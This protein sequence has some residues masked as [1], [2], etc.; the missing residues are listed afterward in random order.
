MYD[1]T[2]SAIS[3]GQSVFGFLFL[4]TVLVFFHEL[5]HFFVA[6]K[7]GVRVESFS[8]GFGKALIRWKDYF[9]TE[10]RIGWIPMGGYV[11]MYGDGDATSAPD[12]AIL[13]KMSD[14]EKK[15]AFHF[16]SLWRRAL[17]IFAGPMANYII[18]IIVFASFSFVYG[19]DIASNEVNGVVDKMPAA[20]AG[21]ISGDK[22]IAVNGQ[23]VDTSQE[24]KIAVSLNNQNDN[25]PLILTI[26]RNGVQRI[27]NIQPKIQESEHRI[28]GKIKI[29]TLGIIF[30]NRHIELNLLDSI[31]NATKQSYSM[32]ITILK[33][34]GQILS[35]QRGFDEFSGPLK[36]AQY[37][38]K[39]LRI[40]IL[41]LFQLLGVI[42][43]NLG[44]INLLPIPPLDG[45]HLF[46]YMI[47]ALLGRSLPNKIQKIAFR[48][49]FA[50]F[51][52][53]MIVSTWN[54]IK[55]FIW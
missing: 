28:Y 44:L 27:L 30:K 52:L 46:M 9:G 7:M 32:S 17:I 5:G 48:L 42:S 2:Q 51:I 13:G 4:I 35:G 25:H 24:V 15:Y 54:D 23:K 40:S 6:R 11:K 21:M 1:L 55:S 19:I 12:V 53:L 45:G 34:I 50:M 37:S 20:Y 38:G 41:E 47:E 36:I 43:L 33:G 49:G 26:E 39:S 3:L 16:Q 31:W 14:D 22:I 10:W 8:I 18:A 29:P